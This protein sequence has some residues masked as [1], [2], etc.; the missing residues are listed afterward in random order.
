MLADKCL[1]LDTLIV[2]FSL[3]IAN[4]ILIGLG[5]LLLVAGD[6]QFLDGLLAVDALVI[7]HLQPLLQHA[8]PAAEVVSAFSN[9]VE[10]YVFAANH[11]LFHFSVRR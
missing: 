6:E 7:H 10:Y 5:G 11:A 3:W 4:G 9:R 8:V 1:A 2:E